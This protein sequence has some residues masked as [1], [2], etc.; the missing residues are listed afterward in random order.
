MQKLSV[1]V[2]S[3]AQLKPPQKST[4]RTMPKAVSVPAAQRVLGRVKK[5]HIRRLR[6]SFSPFSAISA[7]AAAGGVSSL[8]VGSFPGQRRSLAFLKAFLT[9]LGALVCGTWHWVQNQRVRATSSR[10]LPLRST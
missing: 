6:D 10:G 2:S 5:R 1:L 3:I 4:P 9:R 8:M 7:A